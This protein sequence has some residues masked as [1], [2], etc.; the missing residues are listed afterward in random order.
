[1][2]SNE[3][4]SN[5][6]QIYSRCGE[7]QKQEDEI[8][9]KM[10]KKK[11][12]LK[13]LFLIFGIILGLIVL[14]VSIYF[15][16]K[17]ALNRNQDDDKTGTIIKSPEKRKIESEPG[18][19]FPAQIGQFNTIKI[20]QHYDEVSI[21]YGKEIT[22]SFTKIVIYDIYILSEK[23]PSGDLKY[24]YSKLYTCAISIVA[25]C[26]AL[27][28]EED[29]TPH[30][31]LDLT[32]KSIPTESEIRNLQEIEN[33]EDLA[34]PLC[35]F[36]IT[37]NNGITSIKCP[38]AMNEGKMKGIILDIYFY[39]P[40]GVKRLDKEGNNITI[41][42][43]KF[44]NGTELIN[45]KNG[46]KCKGSI[47]A[48]CTT[49][50]NTTKDSN[51]NL[52]SYKEIATTNNII[53]EQ[54]K[55]SK[56][57]ESFLEDITDKN[58]NTK[59]EIYKKN[60]EKL[61]EKL[62]PYLFYYEQV[63]EEQFKELYDL[64]V[65]GNLPESKKIRKR[66]LLNSKDGLSKEE[67]AF[68]YQSL[69]G[70]NISITLS[71]DSSINSEFM[72]A[73]SYF[74]FGEDNEDE[75]VNSNLDSILTKVLNKLI[76]LSKAGNKLADEL[77]QKVIF[78]M[79]QIT[80]EMGSK[81]QSLNNIMVY[82]NITKIFD[83]SL[84]LD[85]LDSL[86]KEIVEES[87]ILYENFNQLL[88]DLK[89]KNTK[90]KFKIINKNI[91]DFL[92]ESHK[93][94]YEV[95]N[96]LRDLGNSMNSEGNK[97]AQ[98]SL[99]YLKHES[100]SYMK[101]IEKAQ[102]IFENYYQ[103]E[104]FLINSNIELLLEN[105]KNN[106]L[107]YSEDE[108]NMIEE[109]YQKLK[110]N[111]FNIEDIDN[112]TNQETINNLK[113]S[114]DMINDI[115]EE[116]TQMVDKELDKKGD[117]FIT[118]SDKK[119]NNISF[120]SSLTK[121]KEISQIV[122]DGQL[123][124]ELYNEKMHYFR[125]NFTEILLNLS[126]EKENLFTLEEEALQYS[127][128]K[129]NAKDK[130]TR[131]F[132][133]FCVNVLKEIQDKSD[134]YEKE[135]NQ[136]IFLFLKENEEELNSLI[137][138]LYVLFSKDSLDE[139]A[140]LY[141][142]EY[143]N[144]SNYISTIITKNED[145]ATQYLADMRK[146]IEDDKYSKE[147]LQAFNESSDLP[148]IWHTWTDIPTHYDE[149]KNFTDEITSKNI[150]KTY[151]DKIKEY[152]AN[153]ENS[154][155]YLNNTLMSDVTYN[156]KKHIINIRKSLQLIKNNK[157]GEKY[158]YYSKIGFDNHKKIIDILFNRLDQYLN[159]SI[160]NEKY[161]DSF[162]NNIS[163][164]IN[165]LQQ[166]ENYINEQN[167]L[168]SKETVDGLSEADN[169]YCVRFQ[170]TANYLCT[171]SVWHYKK[172][173]DNY[174]MKCSTYSNNNIYLKKLSIND[175]F[176][177][178]NSKFNEFY[179]TINEKIN[180]YISKITKLKSDLEK[181]ENNLISDTF[182][183]NQI[184]SFKEE[185][186]TILD[187]YFGDKLIQSSYDYYQ[188]NIE[189]KMDK[190]LNYS[191]VSWENCFD[192]L[193]KEIDENKNRFISS[194]KDFSTMAIIYESVISQN[195]S[196]AYFNSI[197]EKQ[198]VDFNY[199]I[200]YYYNYLLRLINSTNN[201]ILNRVLASQNQFNYVA[202]YKTSLIVEFFKNLTKNIILDEE[203][204][205]KYE[206]QLDFL[207][208]ARSNFFQINSIL[209]KHIQSLES[210]LMIKFRNILQLNN[211]KQSDQFS[212][213]SEMYAENL[214]SSKQITSLY[215]S[216]NDGTFIILNTKN[217]EF[218]DIIIKNNWVFNFDE[219][220]N[221]LEIKLLNLNKEIN[222][223]FLTKRENYKQQL[224]KIIH[225]YFN[226]ESIIEKTIELYNEGIKK[227]DNNL[228]TNILNNINGILN[229]ICDHFTNETKR[230]SNIIESFDN[231][232][233][234]INNTIKEFKIK[235]LNKLNDTLIA[236]PNEFNE[237]IKNKFYTNSVE[238]CLNNFYDHLKSKEENN[239]Y[240]LLNLSYNFGNITNS[241]LLEL[242]KEYKELAQK[243]LS[244]KYQKKIQ[245]IYGIINL[246][247]INNLVNNKID[248]KFENDLLP[249]IKDKFTE[250]AGYKEYDINEDKKNEI[251]SLI[252]K[253]LNEIEKLINS[254]K[255]ENYSI[256]KINNWETSNNFDFSIQ[257][258]QD[259]IQVDIKFDF[260]SFYEEKKKYEED[261]IDQLL[262]EIIKRNFNNSLN[263]LIPS[264]G[265]NYFDK[266][267]KYNENFKIST[268]YDNLR[269]SLSD[270]LA[271]Y[272]IL[273]S[274]IDI[275][276]LPKDLKINLYKL[277]DL[278]E[279]IENKNNEILNKINDI[280]DGF[281]E[282]EHKFILNEYSE[283]FNNEFSVE[284]RFSSK[285]LSMIKQK[286][287]NIQET[288][289]SICK[290]SFIHF[291]KE[292]FIESYKK[293]M[294]KKTYEMLRF[295]NEQIEL[296]RRNVFD[297]LTIDS[298]QV[299][300]E[301]N[302][303]L[304]MTIDSIN[305]YKEHFNSFKIDNEIIKFLN[306]YGKNYIRPLFSNIISIVNEAK[307]N[308][309]NLILDKLEKKSKKYEDLY[310]EEEF[311]ELSNKIY[312]FFKD[313]YEKNLTKY[314]NEYDP[315][316]YKE[317]LQ[318]EK[319]NYEKK[320]LRFLEGNET[321]EDI[322]SKFNEKIADISID[323]T[324]KEILEKSETTRNYL[325]NLKE[326]NTFDDNIQLYYQNIKLN[327]EK[328]KN[329]I[330]EK[331]EN[332]IF[333]NELYENFTEKLFSLHNR[334]IDYY[335]SIKEKYE[336]LKDN[337]TTSINKVDTDLNKCANITYI[338]ITDE[339][340]K[341]KEDIIPSTIQ[342]NFSQ[343]KLESNHLN[344]SYN[345]SNEGQFQYEIDI[346]SNKNAYFSIDLKFENK[347]GKTPTLIAK[348]ENLSGPQN[349]NIKIS[350]GT[351]TCSEK[352][353][354]INANFNSFNYTM[355]IYFNTESTKI[356]ITTFTNFDAYTYNTEDFQSE[357]QKLEGEEK[358]M[359]VNGIKIP[360]NEIYVKC[361]ET[362][363]P[364][365][366]NRIAVKNK[367]YSFTSFL[368]GNS[369]IY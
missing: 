200:S 60:M 302:D 253:K 232:T 132:N 181:I 258:D 153:I 331:K 285:I 252:N 314:I 133:D 343:N 37:D 334:T 237:I 148:K 360:L 78:L 180:I 245:E 267:L 94:I 206:Y 156:Y 352:R 49:D 283:Y 86:P 63:S 234:Q 306:E 29:C 204:L 10:L 174:C 327:Y 229:Y 193:I 340:N 118:E 201:Y 278:E 27:N 15:I 209:N 89:N 199:T 230:L 139:L 315:I 210:S 150:T 11:N 321:E 271:Y 146:A 81:I 320:Y 45:E 194:T 17:Y 140:Q 216:I 121:I 243:Q 282:K 205:L 2:K 8:E 303:K 291:L 68:L 287:F 152:L 211:N 270:T 262:E 349:L 125:Q 48:I 124:D 23:E 157:L 52:I 228:K 356:N 366:K 82:E 171:N 263:N 107:K 104:A 101:T 261:S 21:S 160:Y 212:I 208:V 336:E 44:E 202:D 116:I 292:P 47:N 338:T 96:N 99:H 268:L 324:F 3:V 323:N 119:T 266:V 151:K 284:N 328:S 110:S 298:D 264:F 296:I 286:L 162:K 186:N 300:N 147:M 58:N 24:C 213:S 350:S 50:M 114:T 197:V 218:E 225:R 332:G 364:G 329:I 62:N 76:I 79:E 341:I 126:Q 293:V 55:Y 325:N 18:F 41:K 159:D 277:N 246:D 95:S 161:K 36:N 280:L 196:N 73:N 345:Y 335:N 64:S 190:F 1:M 14:S 269:F 257:S 337:L 12:S 188:N 131:K 179:S 301:V 348:I 40:P 22:T 276:A 111:I 342:T 357:K 170:R 215:N 288:I 299:L 154:K 129:E 109:L 207:G 187:E 265:K 66:K 136:T 169:D 259:I 84:D 7:R 317:N 226:K 65:N 13:K 241:I 319:N 90:E 326:F 308:N 145:L 5:E 185:I 35:L 135:I 51:G 130:I 85:D 97:F 19:S 362:P 369:L 91:Y 106:L 39:R 87:E 105:F 83:D 346:D 339:Y 168:I 289:Q 307:K 25:E 309:K 223:D 164:E 189:I 102:E 158:P 53:D 322:K 239:D 233:I 295:A 77:Y 100:S 220:N 191:L 93:L 137:S 198:K 367:F 249:V 274:S 355:L 57:K 224:E 240:K 254:T 172:Y 318:N 71:D 115:I 112:I 353:K 108:K 72:K 273:T 178:F 103:N 310:Q 203:K 192:S 231:S 142:L 98:I 235:I 67:T 195:I 120:T 176:E 149:L 219:L 163:S 238:K 344:Y 4:N 117:Y 54:N 351:S 16:V 330:E 175:N 359:I 74:K 33:I 242:Q 182:I 34:I 61:L 354:T 59:G 113:N 141:D 69:I 248:K 305:K 347:K 165:Y 281:I 272:S 361:I 143:N 236:I 365:S 88:E 123:V 275:N 358:F 244:Y 30:T 316:N 260:E 127:L 255:K 31:I 251:N 70:P 122:D 20:R 256:P 290:D 38:K 304:N 32:D 75:L 43:E 214:E 368:D 155:D 92:T 279:T 42:I 250:N 9:K 166:I 221:E 311:I 363:I 173:T 247:E 297:K 138:D 26:E 184:S 183:F 177:I 217:K 167:N 294:N 128:F 144:L 6:A 312:S 56:I 80:E 222:E 227:Y 46:G 313:N 28:K 134:R 333:D